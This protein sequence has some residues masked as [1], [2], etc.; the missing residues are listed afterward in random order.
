M[1]QFAIHRELLLR[2]LRITQFTDA[3]CFRFIMLNTLHFSLLVS[4]IFAARR[5]Y[6]SAALV[7]V[8]LS[9]CPSVRLSVIR[10]L[11]HKT[12]KRNQTM[13]CGYFDTTRNGNH[14]SF[15]TPTVVDGRR[16]LPSKICAQSDP[17]P[18][19]NAFSHKITVLEHASRSLSA[20]AELLVSFWYR[21]V[22]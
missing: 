12:N 9:V 5:S 16:P 11:C 10:V 15:L 4:L 22:D 20:I 17:P 14:S 19:K 6:A 1:H 2:W 3:L 7:V 21:A 18:S 8:I 13:H